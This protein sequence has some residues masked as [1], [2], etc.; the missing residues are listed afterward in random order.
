MPI[1]N[2]LFLL[3]S[4]SAF[5]F[6]GCDSNDD[7]EELYLGVWEAQEP[8]VDGGVSR[9]FVSFTEDEIDLYFFFE[10]I[11]DLG[12]CYETDTVDIVRR[13]G[14]TW[15]LRNSDGEETE[16]TFRLDGDELVITAGGDTVRFDRSDRRVSSFT[17]VCE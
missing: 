7:E 13:D 5:T 8:D 15:T 3:I 10:D 11:P 6:A 2:L 1:R 16:S 12:D 17:P 14:T 4:L 9:A